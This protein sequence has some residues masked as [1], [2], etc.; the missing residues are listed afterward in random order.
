MSERSKNSMKTNFPANAINELIISRSQ[1]KA[2]MHKYR[3]RFNALTLKSLKM[4][5]VALEQLII[6]I[7]SKYNSEKSD[8]QH[9]SQPPVDFMLNLQL[10][11]SD[12]SSLVHFISEYNL[13]LNLHSVGNCG[14]IE[15]DL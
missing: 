1:V 8:Q 4:I 5:L 10:M 3:S 14:Q 6:Y 9:Y 13:S 15:S 2:Y 12:L 7:R 11:R